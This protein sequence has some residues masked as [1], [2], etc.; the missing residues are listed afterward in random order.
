VSACHPQTIEV[1]KTRALP[2]GIEVVVG[3]TAALTF[4]TPVFGALLQYPAT[5][6]AVTTTPALSPKPTTPKPWSPWRPIC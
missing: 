4:S 2:L 6:G 3:T 5:D 1:V